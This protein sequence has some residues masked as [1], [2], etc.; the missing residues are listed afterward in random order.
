MRKELGSWLDTEE[1][2]WQQRSRNIYSVVGD[3]NTR[4]FHVKASNRNPKNLIESMEDSSGTWQ[5]T[6]EAIEST[7]I[8]YFSLLFT[9]SNPSDIG[10]VVDIVQ[11]VVSDPMNSLLGSDFQAMEV[12]QALNQ[13]HPTM[14]LALMVCLLSFLKNS[15]LFLVIV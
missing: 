9:T 12:Q 8:D 7:V 15:G 13:M 5:D 10:R 4:F 1:V 11:V 14:A 3:W 6:L 2:M